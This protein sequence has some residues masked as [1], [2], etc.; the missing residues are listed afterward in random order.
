[1]SQ[2][3]WLL[4]WDFCVAQKGWSTFA[5]RA[6]PIDQNGQPT[7][8]RQMQRILHTV[9]WI[10][11]MSFCHYSTGKE[12]SRRSVYRKKGTSEAIMTNRFSPYSFLQMTNFRCFRTCISLLVTLKTLKDAIRY[13]WLVGVVAPFS[14][15]N[16]GLHIRLLVF[17]GQCIK[18]GRS[19]RYV[20]VCA[21]HPQG[22]PAYRVTCLCRL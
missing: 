5:G 15:D 3:E 12:A 9:S 22:R 18:V 10:F 14:F 11:W 19:P 20:P 16:R 6:S 21:Y 1:M 7:T 8:M 2:S 17:W 13:H 4:T